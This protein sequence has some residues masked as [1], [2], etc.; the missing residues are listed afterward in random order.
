MAVPGAKTQAEMLRGRAQT[1]A[2]AELRADTDRIRITLDVTPPLK[3]VIDRL[4][5]QDGTTQADVLRRAIALLNAVKKAEASGEGEAALV[6][7]DHL[8][9][10]QIGF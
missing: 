7:D 1:Q 8:V 9:A 10:K 4:A 6:K 3:A 5:E 2:L